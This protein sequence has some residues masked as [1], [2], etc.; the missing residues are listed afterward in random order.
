MEADLE[1]FATAHKSNTEPEVFR[2]VPYKE[3][4]PPAEQKTT[5]TT[6]QAPEKKEE[7]PAEKKEETEAITNAE[8]WMTVVI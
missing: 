2:F 3:P 5:T 6:E 1:E 4:Q 7:E 8:L